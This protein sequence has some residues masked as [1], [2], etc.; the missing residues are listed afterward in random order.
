MRL[1]QQQINL[2]KVLLVAG[3]VAYHF[4]SMNKKGQYIIPGIY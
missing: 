2:L 4:H 3:L 1:N